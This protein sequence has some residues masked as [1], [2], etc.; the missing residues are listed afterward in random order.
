MA[1]RAYN[2][3]LPLP[4]ELHEMLRAESEASGEPATNLARAALTDWLKSR[5]RER[6]HA[7]IAAF[8]AEN[9]GTD[10]DLD[11]DLEAAG[12]EVLEVDG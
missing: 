5:K 1:T 2:F 12:I 4:Q 11:R 8:A 10:F 6:R 3:H 9:A 7:E